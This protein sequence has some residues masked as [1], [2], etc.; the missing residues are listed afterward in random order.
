MIRQLYSIGGVLLQHRS[1]DSL[2]VGQH[3]W[4]ARKFEYSDSAFLASAIKTKILKN[5]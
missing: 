1:L 3:N 2:C 4:N 5:F